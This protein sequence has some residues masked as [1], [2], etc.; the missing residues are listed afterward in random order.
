M[1]K[2]VVAWFKDFIDFIAHDTQK[3]LI[4]L[5]RLVNQLHFRD[6]LSKKAISEQLR[7]SKNFVI[8]WIQSMDQDVTIDHRGWPKGRRRR[9]SQETEGRIAS[10]HKELK[11]GKEGKARKR[12]SEGSRRMFFDR[13]QPPVVILV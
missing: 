3:K 2:V 7:V 4:S 1:N 5:R 6:G 9:W 12:K 10:L 13:F 8:R 11:G